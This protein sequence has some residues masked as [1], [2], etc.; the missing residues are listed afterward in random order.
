MTQP[1]APAVTAIR[2]V[3]VA[4]NYINI[5]WDSVGDGFT[6]DVYRKAGNSAW[7]HVTR[8]LNTS[9][10]DAHVINNTEYS[11]KIRVIAQY[12]TPSDYTY[13]ETITTFDQNAFSITNKASVFPYDEFI[14]KKLVYDTNHIDFNSSE[15]RAVLM[16]HNYTFNSAHANIQDPEVINF[17]IK[18]DEDV[19]LYGKTPPGCG[20]FGCTIPVLFN[21]ALILFEKKQDVIKI[22]FDRGKTWSAV[23][24]LRDR[25]GLPY[26]DSIYTFFQGALVVLGYQKI[27]I[28]RNNNDIRWSSTEHGF[29]EVDITFDAPNARLPTDLQ[30]TTL[31]NYP[32]GV[33]PGTIDAICS[34]NDRYIYVIS[35]QYTYRYDMITPTVSGD[36]TTWDPF[37]I[38]FPSNLKVRNMV[39]LDG[40]VYAFA[41]SSY[42]Y[43]A[44]TPIASTDAGVYRLNTSNQS[45]EHVWGNTSDERTLI[46]IEQSNLTRNKDRLV[47]G[48]EAE[49]YVIDDSN[50][51]E[52]VIDTASISAWSTKERP[53][54]HIFTS[55]DGDTWTIAR[56]K[57]QYEEQYLWNG[58]DRVW[59]NDLNKI[60]VIHEEQ[61]FE[62]TLD[63]SEVFADGTYTFYGN[64]FSF[65]NFPGYTLGAVVYDYPTGALICYTSLPIK[66]RVSAEFTWLRPDIILRATLKTQAAE[67]AIADSDSF[68]IPLLTPFA[69]RFIPEH[70]IYD[71][72]KFVEF[73]RLYL[74]YI[75][76][77]S[78]TNYGALWSLLRS[79]DAN[80]TTFIDMFETDLSRRNIRL[81][82]EK[83]AE[84]TKFLY[85]RGRDFY[86]IKGTQDS[87]K[88][89]F[90]LLYNRDVN[91]KIESSYDFLYQTDVAIVSANGI[92]VTS[93]TDEEIELIAK[94][95]VGQKIAQTSTGEPSDPVYGEIVAVFYKEMVQHPDYPIGTLIPSYTIN[96]V[97]AYGKFEED[98][99]YVTNATDYTNI[100]TCLR[101]INIIK[102]NF[103]ADSFLD[104]DF[105]FNYIIRIESDLPISRYYDDVIRFVHPVGF[106]FIGA[107]LITSF[108]MN[109]VPSKHI[110]TI[111][112]FYQGLRWD[113]GLPSVYPDYL[114]DLDGN[115]EYQFTTDG[116]LKVVEYVNAGDPFV[117]ATWEVANGDTYPVDVIYG[118]TPDQRRKKNSPLFDSS[119]GRFYDRINNPDNSVYNVTGAAIVNYMRP[120]YL[121]VRLK[122]NLVDPD[123]VSA[124]QRKKT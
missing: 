108:I 107:Y 116:L 75:S 114:P 59:I 92:P 82:T 112:D 13:S 101:P 8:T 37:I 36:E 56:E 45:W 52:A 5:Q 83:R 88:F 78:Q 57:W 69:E 22:T 71:E 117:I 98:V 111:I 33:F 20:G 6:Y 113:S 102:N 91:V 18:T 90:K 1:N 97:N 103:S 24:A 48:V 79:H 41:P 68:N 99:N 118:E 50:P 10:Y 63:T 3:N 73:V 95:M 49:K 44:K 21:G 64:E 47:L 32:S 80:E 54:R 26:H 7:V 17:I 16:K 72:P 70:Y 25:A 100:V 115:D 55:L 31:T 27:L 12:Y 109:D 121:R 29:S 77:G 58:G 94:S 89:L 35:G 124:T 38:G 119:W 61:P 19:S 15:I 11:Y 43:V 51:A 67:S 30:F 42:D 66:T 104:D 62:V 122:D 106:D 34:D 23:R 85:N 96:M 60:S 105:T 74:Q 120:E 123:N 110:E 84:I 81:D 39:E 46:N 2:F 40:K 65:E 86:S 93:Y 4:A 28:V 87:Y 53:Y 14:Q 76:D 9:L